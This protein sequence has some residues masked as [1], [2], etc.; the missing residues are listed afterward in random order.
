M[1]RIY[2]V[3]LELLAAL[4]PLMTQIDKRDSDLAR[5]MRRAATSVAL[6]LGEGMYS[7]GKNRQVRYHS[8]LASMRETVACIEVAVALGYVARADTN[9]MDRMS[10]VTG[11]LVKLVR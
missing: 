1:L 6:N 3:V 4:R 7:R 9:L 2:P 11:T 8:A 5:Q 10:L